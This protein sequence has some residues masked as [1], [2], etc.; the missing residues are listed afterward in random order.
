MRTYNER[1][2]QEIAKLNESQRRAVDHID[3]PVLVIAG[4]GTGKT[5]ILAARIGRILLETDTQAQN[6]LC[7]TFTDSGVQAMRKRLLEWIGPEAHRVHIYTFHSFC[8][9][10][11]QDN[12]ELFGHR[13]LEPISDLERIELIRDLLGE[14]PSEHLLKRQVG[15][16]F[17]YEQQLA[18]LFQRIKGENWGAEHVLEQIDRYVESLPS[19]EKYRYKVNTRNNKK[20]DLKEADYQAELERMEKLKSGVLLYPRFQEMMAE[21]RRYDYDDMILWVLDAFRK[22]PFP[23]SQLPGALPVF[24]DRRIPGHKRRPAL[25]PPA[26]DQLLGGAQRIY[27]G[28]RRPVDL[29]IPGRQA[30]KPGRFLRILPRR[31]GDCARGKLPLG[32]GHSGC[33]PFPYRAERKTNCQRPERSRVGKKLRAANAEMSGLDVRPQL[34]SYPNPLHELSDLIHQVE[35]L[36]EK[37]VPLEEIAFI[38]PQHKQGEW[39]RNLLGKRGIPYQVKRKVNILDLPLIRQ[40]R[41]LLEY[42]HAEQR[43]PYS[44]EAFLFPLL[45]DGYWG[46]SPQGLTMLTRKQKRELSGAEAERIAWRDFLRDPE[47]LAGCSGEDRAAIERCIRLM[48]EFQAELPGWPLPKALE[49][50]FTRAGILDF[51]LKRPQYEDLLQAASTLMAFAQTEAVRNPRLTVEGFLQTLRKMDANGLALE[52]RKSASLEKGVSL[53]T[54]HG[55]KGL[56]FDY[57]FLLDTTEGFWEPKNNHGSYRFSF[58]DTLTFSGE[59]DALEARRRLFYVA[60]T[61]ARKGL[62]ISYSRTTV[63]VKDQTQALFFDEVAESGLLREEKEVPA[64]L[65]LEMEALW[66]REAAEK[67]AVPPLD[68]EEA[69]ARLTGFQLSISALNTYLRC[70]LSFFFEYVLQAPQLESVGGLYGTAIHRALQSY[71]N[72]MKNATDRAF[73]LTAILPSLFEAEWSAFRAFIPEEDFLHRLDMGKRNLKAYADHHL[74]SWPR[75]I[76]TELNLRQVELGGVPIQG[77]LDKVEYLDAVHVRLVDYKTGKPDEKK[78][79]GPGKKEPTGSLYWR[80][81]AFY[82]LLFHASREGSHLVQSTVLS[83]VDPDEKG[84]FVDREIVFEPDELALMTRLIVETYDHI[85]KLEFYHGCGER[86]CAW[87]NFVREKNL[88]SELA[89]LEVEELDDV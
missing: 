34:V 86:D 62:H 33:R 25:G 12:L 4:P 78:W 89:D 20:G 30:K 19:R 60:M 64:A 29:R 1:F 37:G 21:R 85:M 51:I 15:N 38:Y 36:R 44:G 52:L 22:I 43:E 3:G 67:P 23:A 69:A 71:F 53:L 74:P 87:C 48:D 26:P 54:A 14:L 75:D 59:E 66:L 49:A 82:Q 47:A 81:M 17:Q 9:T 32:P 55:A 41:R 72:R 61:R 10:I 39:L 7:L 27:R 46:I 80:Q 83:F 5:H 16:P 45:H 79:K 73:P 70:P 63:Q 76:R 24:S 58:P 57:V 28:R 50:L 77:K 68:P 84:R 42:L 13:N 31:R 6:I 11:I 18:D 88:L 8:N 35:L 2:L 65:V 40:I 56:E